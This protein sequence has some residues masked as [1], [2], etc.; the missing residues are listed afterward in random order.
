MNESGDSDP[1]II[2]R[3]AGRT[4]QSTVKK[5]SINPSWYETLSLDVSFSDI[6]ESLSSKG[7]MCI[8][9]DK[10][11][12]VD[13]CIGRFW[14]PIH[15]QNKIKFRSG[16]E[17]KVILHQRPRWFYVKNHN[18]KQGRDNF[19]RVLVGWSLVKD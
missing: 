4:I 12:K 16:R 18:S 14:V 1:Y 9:M 2:F 13:K 8:M 3:C 5:N 10:E 17:Q 11:E 6:L 15:P 7:I 19:G